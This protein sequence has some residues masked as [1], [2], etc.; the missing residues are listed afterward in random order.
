MWYPKKCGTILVYFQTFNNTVI[1]S[2]DDGHVMIHCTCVF[3][4]NPI[5]GW[6]LELPWVVC[7]Y[8]VNPF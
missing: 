1:I 4:K 6:F 2:C 7:V 3:F 5:V 8:I